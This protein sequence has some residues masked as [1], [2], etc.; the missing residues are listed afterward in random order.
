MGN[1]KFKLTKLALALGLTATLSGCFGDNDNN[2]YVKEPEKPSATTPDADTPSALKFYI[3]ANV[4][5]IATGDVVDAKV[6]FI[7]TDIVDISGASITELDAQDGN[8]AFNVPDT[9]DEATLLVSAEGYVTKA[10]TIDTSE[11]SVALQALIPLASEANAITAQKTD[12]AADAGKLVNDLFVETTD[13]SAR[14]DVSKDVE[15]QDAEGN[16]ITGDNVTMKVVTAP[17]NAEDGKISAAQLIPEGLNTNSTTD[18]LSAAAVVKISMSS[19]DTKIKNFSEDITVKAT[20]PK[21]FVKKDGTKVKAGDTFGVSTYDEE[22]RIWKNESDVSA[23]VGAEGTVNFPATYKINHL[24]TH[25][26]TET[27]QACSSAVSVKFTGA[28]VPESG[29]FVGIDTQSNF[30]VRHITPSTQTLIP[31]S[32]A[33]QLGFAADAKGDFY[34]FDNNDNEWAFKE[35][36]NI[37]GEITATLANEAEVVNEEFRLTYSCS[38]A[39]DTTT[40]LP[41]TGALVTYSL[42]GKVSTSANENADGAYLMNN[43]VKA[44]TATYTVNVTPTGGNIAPQTFTITPD[45]TAEPQNIV[46]DNCTLRDVTGTGTGTTGGS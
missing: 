21:D 2:D 35:N 13:G 15:L 25:L 22:T 28:A 34:V 38:N 42:A 8:F 16:V 46:R 26:L 17:L 27:K 1:N 18:V 40:Q 19:G 44:D 33:A 24:S 5:D 32:I 23:T 6:T 45:G 9:R 37:C 39:T 3:N 29:L 41:L 31:Q 43:L 11:K 14:V 20:L 4:V 7:E 30:F 10:V 12:V 36:V